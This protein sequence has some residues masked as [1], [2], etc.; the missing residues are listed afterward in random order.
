MMVA[1]RRWL[2]GMF[3]SAFKV[4]VFLNV[5]RGEQFLDDDDLIMDLAEAHQK[6]AV[7]GGGVDFVAQPLQGDLGG[8]KPFG[9]G[10]GDQG[11]LVRRC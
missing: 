8:L 1:W 5:V 4:R 11:G 9:R 6:I 7:R 3:C 10:K 2:M